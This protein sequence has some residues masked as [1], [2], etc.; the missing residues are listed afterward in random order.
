MAD[1]KTEQS[2]MHG[3]KLSELVQNQ[4]PDAVPGEDKA[5]AHSH[6]AHLATE[7][8]A[9]TVPEGNHKQGVEPGAL[10]EPPQDP[11]RNGKSVR[12]Q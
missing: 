11:G 7:G 1:L 6:A 8:N 2:R 3:E 5:H 12:R 4:H 10:R 9:H